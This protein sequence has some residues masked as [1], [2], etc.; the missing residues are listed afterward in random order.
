MEDSPVFQVAE[1]G[2]SLLPMVGGAPLRFAF[3]LL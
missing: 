2:F 3:I 1:F